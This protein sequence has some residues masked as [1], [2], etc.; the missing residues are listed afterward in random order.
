[1][2]KGGTA[3]LRSPAPGS[4]VGLRLDVV[5]VVQGVGFRPFVYR[6]ASEL[7]LAGWI[8][9]SNTGV[10]IELDGPEP[11]LH[12]FLQRLQ[13]EA[14]PLSRVEIG[15][16]SWTA[17][18]GHVQFEIRSSGGL[19]D[20]RTALAPPDIAVCAT[21]LQEL[22]NPFDRRYR[23]PFINCTHCGPRFSIIQALPYDRAN[24]SMHRFRLCADCEAEYRNPADRRFHAQ[25]NAC[26]RCGPHLEFW[27]ESGQRMHTHEEALP[28]A[29]QELQRGSIVAVKGLG[30]F[31]LMVLAHDASAVERLRKRKH[32]EE[33]PFA[34]MLESIESAGRDC[35]I[36]KL[37]AD[38]LLSP[39]APIVLLDRRQHS[40]AYAGVAPGNPRLGVMLPS[41]PLHH[42]LLQELRAPV[43]ATSGNLSEEPICTD[44]HEAVERLRGIADFFLV[45]NRPIV[46]PMDDSV[47]IITVG[48]EMLLR[49]ARGYAPLPIEVPPRATPILATGGQLKNTIALAVDGHAFISQHIGDLENERGLQTF[50]STVRSLENLYEARPGL[51]VC[52]LHPDYLSTIEAQNQG[53]PWSPVQHHV[54]HVFAC[55]TENHLRPPLLGVAWDGNG[56]G[57]DGTIWG[58]EFFLVTETR[59]ERCA[60][61]R[62]FPL[63]GG[64]KAAREPR[65]AAAG[66]LFEAFG[67]AWLER[68]PGE[69]RSTF[70]A[71]EA[72]MLCSMLERGVNCPRTSSVGRLFDAVAALCGLCQH[73]SFEG[74]AA[75]DLEFAA[76]DPVGSFSAAPAVNGKNPAVVDWSPLVSR[77][78]EA[79][80]AGEPIPSIAA[81][82]H[83]W[84]A[85]AL[86]EIARRIGQRQVCLSGGCFQNRR[87]T[88]RAVTRL[89]SAGFAPFW[90]RQVPPNDGGL[91]LGQI[92]AALHSSHVSGH[93]R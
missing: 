65:Y 21:C 73:N 57:T 25:P 27:D 67:P 23:Y 34:L 3:A 80:S 30:G 15:S 59:L 17:P 68:A 62:S 38:L 6:L 4:R 10:T 33:K 71:T 44:E 41:T 35:Q 93:T 19:P 28:A 77:I 54:A 56:L 83:D 9:N 7:N 46:R 36:S 81:L 58:G 49:R 24:T 66:L 69:L 12:R 85:A 40:S 48:R 63:P 84:L 72:K 18:L 82:F 16:A 43:V 53:A 47:A 89:R 78:L 64:D 55:L 79:L 1:M 8:R 92:A 91:S 52:D 37:E 22:R 90:H 42:L 39:Q 75:M 32:R 70:H 50:R 14:P 60:H 20:K 2:T 29:A 87:L 13:A 26:P 31:H 11:I 61:F 74:Q 5:G 51:V 76:C 86:V 45:H 88:E